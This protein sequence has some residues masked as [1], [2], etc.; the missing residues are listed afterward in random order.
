[1]GRELI[2]VLTGKRTEPSTLAQEMANTPWTGIDID[3]LLRLIDAQ[4]AV[5]DAAGAFQRALED[6]TDE[7]FGMVAWPVEI[8]EAGN[9]M[10][11]ALAQLGADDD[12]QTE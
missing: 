1:L 12:A 11:D 3:T 5:I 2:E 9:E 10:R 6:N 8:I 4:Q 7:E